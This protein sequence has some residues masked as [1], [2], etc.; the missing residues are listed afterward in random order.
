ML[1]FWLDSIDSFVISSDAI[2]EEDVKFN[3]PSGLENYANLMREDISEIGCVENVCDPGTGTKGTLV[4]C[5]T[6]QE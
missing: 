1:K 5:L 6:N 3:N 2:G 4:Y